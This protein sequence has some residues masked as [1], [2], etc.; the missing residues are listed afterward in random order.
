MSLQ[1]LW[2]ATGERE[3]SVHMFRLVCHTSLLHPSIDGT[4]S[5]IQTAESSK[6][7][8]KVGSS[9]HGR[10]SPRA[11]R[12][13]RTSER[14]LLPQVSHLTKFPDFTKPDPVLDTKAVTHIP[15]SAKHPY[16]ATVIEYSPYFGASLEKDLPKNGDGRALLQS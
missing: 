2:V 14:K 15:A 4:E 11:I 7:A 5:F 10:K 1:S 12:L 6:A 13:Q 9:T 16:S 8:E 3:F